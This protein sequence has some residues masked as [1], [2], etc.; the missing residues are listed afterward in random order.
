MKTRVRWSAARRL[1]RQMA[2]L[3]W[4]VAAGYVVVL[5]VLGFVLAAPRPAGSDAL[6]ALAQPG[7][8]S[9]VGTAATTPAQDAAA[10]Q[11]TGIAWFWTPRSGSGLLASA[12]RAAIP[13][14]AT[15]TQEQAET[16]ALTGPGLWL[17][18]LLGV[19]PF[20]PR[21]LLAAEIPGMKDPGPAEHGE[22]SDR[23]EGEATPQ[24]PA[25]VTNPLPVVTG[26]DPL[27]A[28][29]HTHAYE[30]YT[31]EVK[32]PKGA[33]LSYAIS[34]DDQHS[35]VAAGTRLAQDLATRGVPAVHSEAH[36]G[37]QVGAYVRSRQTAAKMLQQYPSVQ[38]LLDVHRDSQPRVLTT[39]MVDGKPAARIMI[40]IAKGTTGLKQPYYPKNLEFAQRLYANVEKRYPG[41]MRPV[42]EE[43]ARY[44]QDLLPGALL[45]EVGGPENSLEEVFRSIDLLAPVLSDQL[46]QGDFPRPTK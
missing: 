46:R 2:R 29:Y 7:A 3:D 12:L 39:A 43:P 22:T 18:R 27:V 23:T 11:D 14:L 30:S 21:S 38:V 19:N 4:K 37:P 31:S 41:L 40:V 36:H 9:K 1:G 35:I 15:V 10:A 42:Y 20:D 26:K 45:L 44:N 17:R 24:Q 5:T 28:I 16:P 34:N 32:L 6:P 13:A 25:D 33:P 8:G